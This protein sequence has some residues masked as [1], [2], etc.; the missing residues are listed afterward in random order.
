M[1][2]L[3]SLCICSIFWRNKPV[4]E[5]SNTA[6]WIQFLPNALIFFIVLVAADRSRFTMQSIADL[7]YEL[8]QKLNI[9]QISY[10]SSSRRLKRL[11]ICATFCVVCCG[12]N[13]AIWHYVIGINPSELASKFYWLSFVLAKIGLLTFNFMFSLYMTLLLERLRIVEHTIE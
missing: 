12:S 11:S 8:D 3:Y 2:A 9:F 5:I 4:S 1:I 7:I 6:N 10:G 13:I